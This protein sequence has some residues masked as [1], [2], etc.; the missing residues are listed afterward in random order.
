M[1]EYK[2][3]YIKIIKIEAEDKYH[4]QIE[5]ING[6]RIERKGSQIGPFDESSHKIINDNLSQGPVSLA[7]EVSLKQIEEIEMRYARLLQ[8]HQSLQS[9][10]NVISKEN[11]ELKLLM[12]KD[13][14]HDLE[15]LYGKGLTELENEFLQAEGL[16][17]VDKMNPNQPQDIGDPF[18][19]ISSSFLRI[20]KINTNSI[21][22]SCKAL[23]SSDKY[24]E[25][26][27]LVID[28]ARLIAD[29]A[30]SPFVQIALYNQQVVDLYCEIY[31]ALI[32]K[33]IPMTK[34][35]SM[36]VF[37]SQPEHQF[38]DQGKLRALQQYLG[39]VYTKNT[40]SYKY[41]AFYLPVVVDWMRKGCEVIGT[42]IIVDPSR[43]RDPIMG[44]HEDKKAFK[45]SKLSISAKSMRAIGMFAN[46]LLTDIMARSSTDQH[47]SLLNLCKEGV[48]LGNI[49]SLEKSLPDLVR[50]MRLGL[51]AALDF[52]DVGILLRN[53][54]EKCLTSYSPNFTLD[55]LKKAPSMSPF[56]Y[57]QIDCLSTV[58]LDSKLKSQLIFK[59][60]ESAKFLQGVDNLT[61]VHLL[62]TIGNQ[63]KQHNLRSA[64]HWN[65]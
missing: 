51:A 40:I 41:D 47:R 20:K 14:V 4:Q 53:F 18:A 52:E 58:F 25:V 23:K 19:G 32:K 62:L 9:R 59:P 43:K 65:L 49:L 30:N 12:G 33:I 15:S 21:D 24:K 28:F 31:P 5:E 29:S 44:G 26:S 1:N 55:E 36:L 54:R 61:P 60:R 57:S 13:R 35:V 8:D 56:N 6:N 16:L 46:C 48:N 64:R 17:K 38:E 63:P 3:K 50:K 37:S 10:L 39:E 7:D 45:E 2:K 11:K 42:V 27:Q 22:F 34:Y